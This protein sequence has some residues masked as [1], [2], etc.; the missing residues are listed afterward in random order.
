MNDQSHE[1]SY[2]DENSVT[3][4]MH[5]TTGEFSSSIYSSLTPKGTYPADMLTPRG[6]PDLAPVRSHEIPFVVRF[7]HSISSRL[8]EKVKQTNIL[9]SSNLGTYSFCS[10]R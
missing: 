1:T 6:N 3:E 5:V 8:N 2:E 4:G 7:L 9:N 10:E